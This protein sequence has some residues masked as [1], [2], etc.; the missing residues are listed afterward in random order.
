MSR[1][2]EALEKSDEERK[3]VVAR[4]RDGHHF[5]GEKT[6]LGKSFKPN[7]AG[8]PSP[9]TVRTWRE[10][11][12]EILFGL[13]L[14]HYKSY[15]IAAL[16]QSSPAAEQFKIL[17]EQVKRLRLESGTRSVSITSPIKRDGK[18][19]V[20]VN[21]AA[22]L[23]LD[24]DEQVLLIDC[25]LRNPQIHRY[26]GIEPNPGLAD[27]L[28][29][30]SNEDV[31][32]YV[33]DTFLPNLKIFPAGRSPDFSSELLAKQ[34]M[35]NVMEEIRSRFPDHQIIIDSSPVLSTPDP[36]VVARQVDGVIM[37]MRAGKTPRDCLLEAIQTLNS[38]KIMGIVLNDVDLGKT[39]KYY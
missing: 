6:P 19:M 33:K 31:M 36:L 16:E 12:E 3:E 38:N 37:V 9:A 11:V 39:S 7:G 34:K 5:L 30:R 25:D 28:N 35:R 24:Y 15:P 20:A 26:F 27:Y 4:S 21:L 13:D 23:A 29:S 1:V 14:R 10:K 32:T 18:S 17:R 2:F 22:A 8:D